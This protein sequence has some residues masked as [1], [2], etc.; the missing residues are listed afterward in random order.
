MNPGNLTALAYLLAGLSWGLDEPTPPLPTPHNGS[1]IS[2]SKE[3]TH[4]A[5][6]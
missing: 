1:E 6:G 2:S 5:F 4:L 3:S